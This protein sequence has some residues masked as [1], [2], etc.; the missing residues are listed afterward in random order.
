[1]KSFN[2]RI[3]LTFVGELL[4]LTRETTVA[5]VL[6]NPQA[7]EAEERATISSPRT[8]WSSRSANQSRRWFAYQTSLVHDAAAYKSGKSS[9]A[10]AEVKALSSEIQT[11]H[12]LDRANYSPSS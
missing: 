8:P 5:Y 11:L 4:H 10:E 1:M 3:R 6:L 7:S 2:Y 12:K 9:Q